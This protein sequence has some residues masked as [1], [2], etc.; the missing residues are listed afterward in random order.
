[1]VKALGELSERDRLPIAALGV[2]DADQP[3]APGCIKLPGTAGPEIQ[4]FKDVLAAGVPSLARRLELAESSVDDALRRGM[5]NTDHHI[6]IGDSARI[7]KQTR[8]YLWCT[9]C[10]VW[11]NQNQ[12]SHDA[13]TLIEAVRARLK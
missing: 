8:D 12:N 5:T 3:A 4:V 11:V 2:P 9:M 6:W 7:L 10:K 13:K 1:M